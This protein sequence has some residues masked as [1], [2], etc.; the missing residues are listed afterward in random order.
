MTTSIALR[1]LVP[2]NQLTGAVASYYTA[3]SGVSAKI[4]A[5]TVVNT[6]S[7]SHTVSIWIVE[8]GGSETDANLVIDAK[9]IQP[10][11]TYLCPELLAKNVMPGGTIRA[12]AEAPSVLSLQVSGIEVS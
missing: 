11:E 3:Q 8:D 6:D 1:N 9:A 7:G 5:A 12:Q 2:G 10:G 4:N